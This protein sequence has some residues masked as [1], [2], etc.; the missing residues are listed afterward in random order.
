MIC[1]GFPADRR[2]VVAASGRRTGMEAH[3]KECAEQVLVFP[4]MSSPHRFTLCKGSL[5][6]GSSVCERCGEAGAHIGN[7]RLHGLCWFSGR[8]SCCCCRVWE[9]DRK[10]GTRKGMR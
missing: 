5:H 8:E 3:A 1:A 9:K 6:L 10:G 4:A 7:R 2:A